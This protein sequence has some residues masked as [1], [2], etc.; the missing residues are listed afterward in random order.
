M[1]N[2]RRMKCECNEKTEWENLCNYHKR[3]VEEQ[4]FIQNRK[5]GHNW[6][7]PKELWNKFGDEE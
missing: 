7:H 1:E 3:I 2:I 6:N 4:M 5:F